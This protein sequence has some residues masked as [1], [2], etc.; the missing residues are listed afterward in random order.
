MKRINSLVKKSW[1][2]TIPKKNY[3]LPL[4]ST[5]AVQ[6][7]LTRSPSTSLQVPK[8]I[9]RVFQEAGRCYR[10]MLQL[11]FHR[12]LSA[13]W[14]MKSSRWSVRHGC[15]LSRGL[16]WPDIWGPSVITAWAGSPATCFC[17]SPFNPHSVRIRS[18]A[19]SVIWS[20][21]IGL[22]RGRHYGSIEKLAYQILRHRIQ[23][24]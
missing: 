8:R 6:F 17:Y 16:W 11:L 23:I 19:R 5:Y 1:E 12:L 18:F 10:K 3:S 9:W 22:Q 2:L 21:F 7:H 24:Q 4:Y 15:L 20:F 13:Q 14:G